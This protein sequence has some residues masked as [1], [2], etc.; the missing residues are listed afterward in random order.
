APV[1]AAG[2]QDP[3][4]S[5]WPTES[6]SVSTPEEQG[7]DSGNLAR[8]IET[9]GSYRQDSFTIVR[10]GKIVADAY[11]A[12]YVAGISHDLRSVTKSVTGT[13]TA[14]QLQKGV[15][16]SVDHPVIDL[17]SDKRIENVD[18]RKRAMTVQSL[19]GMTSGIRWTE[20]AYTPDET[21]MQM[22]RSHDRTAF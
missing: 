22:Y 21:I 6:W 14:I 1:G 7:M 12:P 17:F 3:Q 19:F 9:V 2:G 13:L 8:L 11:F 10:H 5:P 18:D 16:D 15:L 20:R 4:A